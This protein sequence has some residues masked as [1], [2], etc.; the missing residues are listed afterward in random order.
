MAVHGSTKRK[1]DDVGTPSSRHQLLLRSAFSRAH[2]T[3]SINGSDTC[4]AWHSLSRMDPRQLR[5]FSALPLSLVDLSGS[6]CEGEAMTT[7]RW[8]TLPCLGVPSHTRTSRII[9]LPGSTQ[10]AAKR[11]PAH[12]DAAV[13]L[14]L[15]L[16]CVCVCVCVCVLSI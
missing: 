4:A 2:R 16:H 10:I 7:K 11:L 3:P 13:Q 12:C 8:H 14:W 9:I 5:R 6:V 15:L 1:Q